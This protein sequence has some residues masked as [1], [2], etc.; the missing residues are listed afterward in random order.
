[1]THIKSHWALLLALLGCSGAAAAA[2]SPSVATTAAA[3]SPQVWLER[4]EQALATRNY[5]GVFEHQLAG[6]T[7]SL[8]I[9]HRVQS[10]VAEER[11]VALDGSGREFIRRG[12]ELYR[13]LP[14]QRLVQVEPSRG[15]GTLLADLRR[16]DVAASGQ[17]EVRELP[18]EVSGGRPVH[19]IL[20]QPRDRFR[21]GYQL[22]I[23]ESS[24]MPVKTQ[25]LGSDGRVLEQLQFTELSLPRQVPD[26]LLAAETDATG[27]VWQRTEAQSAI[28]ALNTSMASAW[29]ATDLPPG[30]KMTVRATQ[31]LPGSQQPV[32]QLVYS[33]G[34]AAV[35][36]FVEQGTTPVP[37][38]AMAAE[39]ARLGSSSAYSTVVQG[40]RVTAVGEV[41]PE[42]L[43][44]I[45]TSAV[46]ERASRSGDSRSVPGGMSGGPV[47]GMR[48]P[49]ANVSRPP[50]GIG[51]G[52]RR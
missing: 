52:N 6:Q 16:I 12:G 46:P 11:V 4:M 19:V 30:F 29:Q 49:P 48:G 31:A 3:A 34:L 41:P 15:T 35:S 10:G 14:D 17:Y 47:G 51:P 44:A 1:M 20:V 42:T 21:Y 23:D 2:A 38:D 5:R 37:V 13:Y 8:R 26:S 36:V 43:R 33:D 24:A 25:L 22:W 7:V 28:P 27:F 40:Y 18:A 50:A 39:V 45:A 32:T 9:V